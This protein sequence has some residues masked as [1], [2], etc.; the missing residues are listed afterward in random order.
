MEVQHIPGT[1]KIEISGYYYYRD[2]SLPNGDYRYECVRRRREGCSAKAYLSSD[3]RVQ[4]LVGVHSHG[5]TCANKRENYQHLTQPTWTTHGQSSVNSKRND[6]YE[7]AHEY[8]PTIHTLP[9]WTLHDKHTNLFH[10]N[11]PVFSDMRGY[12]R[13]STTELPNYANTT[14]LRR[15]HTNNS[16]DRPQ[17]QSIPAYGS[18]IPSQHLLKSKENVEVKLI[19]CDQARQDFTAL[20]LPDSTDD[21]CILS[22]QDIQKLGYS[23]LN[24]SAIPLKHPFTAIVNGPT[25]SGKT[26]FCAQLVR[27]AGTMI[28]PSPQRIIWC[29]GIYQHGYS[30]IAH[31]VELKEGIPDAMELDPNIRTLLILD[32]LMNEVD[33]RVSLLFT[34]DSHHRNTSVIFITQN[35]FQESRFGRT[36]NLNAHYL[37][38][39]KNPRDK[40][41]ISYLARQIH[42]EN[43]KFLMTAFDDATARPFGYLFLDLKPNAIEELRVRTNVLEGEKS[44]NGEILRLTIYQPETHC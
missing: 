19:G 16:R 37:V 39:F 42:P 20:Q 38:L 1:N 11:A 2:A 18:Q 27:T 28:Q 4:K 33:E 13:A 8:R 29:Y 17:H 14:Q 10:A 41:Q 22:L 26:E 5:T 25:G 12:T 36:I 43:T 21:N 30:K 15:R 24:Q 6:Q 3:M 44:A 23:P 32:D 40:M 34:R 35:I 31:C 9:P 7:P